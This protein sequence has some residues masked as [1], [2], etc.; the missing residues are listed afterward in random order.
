MHT[1]VDGT[2]LSWHQVRRR[3]DTPHLRFAPPSGKTDFIQ[4]KH[5]QHTYNFDQNDDTQA[6]SLHDTMAIVMHK[7]EVI[8]LSGGDAVF[9]REDTEHVAPQ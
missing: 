6:G 5:L 1:A 3:P 8:A 7:N 4:K 2:R 9:S